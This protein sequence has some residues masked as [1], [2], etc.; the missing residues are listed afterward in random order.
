MNTFFEDKFV[1][2]VLETM[3]GKPTV[4]RQP[5]PPSTAIQVRAGG[6]DHGVDP[7][8]DDRVDN[9]AYD[10]E[11]E[12]NGND[13]KML[14]LVMMMVLMMTVVMME[15]VVFSFCGRPTRRGLHQGRVRHQLGG[16][17]GWR[18]SA[19]SSGQRPRWPG[20]SSGR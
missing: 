16:R 19:C 3:Q 6:W 10:E 20:N 11:D 9:G 15:A 12:D 4:N 7:G 18:G 5:L 13:R 2:G 14:A 17:R 1:D 8:R